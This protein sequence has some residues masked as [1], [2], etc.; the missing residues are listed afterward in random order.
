MSTSSHSLNSYLSSSVSLYRDQRPQE[1]R[2]IRGVAT[3]FWVGGRIVG[4][5]ANLPQNT[6]KIGKDTG[7]WP[8]HSR[9]WGGGRNPR[10]SK[11]RGSGPP[12]PPT[13]PSATPLRR[14]SLSDP[15]VCRLENISSQE[16]FSAEI[17]LLVVS[18]WLRQCRP[19]HGTSIRHCCKRE[20]CFNSSI[21]PALTTVSTAQFCAFSLRDFFFFFFAKN[22]V[23]SVAITVE[24][25]HDRWKWKKRNQ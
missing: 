5:V 19:W 9:I 4:R 25:L 8:L 20:R 15:R 10:F 6:I 3:D 7:F 16:K 12:P 23:R 24:C 14:M 13:P 2:R 18:P 21:Y 11:V 17:A 1:I 22:T